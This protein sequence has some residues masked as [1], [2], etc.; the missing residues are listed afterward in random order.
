MAVRTVYRSR[1]SCRAAA[2]AKSRL[3]L[4]RRERGGGRSWSFRGWARRYRSRRHR[5]DV[6]RGAGRQDCAG[7]GAIRARDRRLRSAISAGMGGRCWSPAQLRWATAGVCAPPAGV[8]IVRDLVVFTQAALGW[9]DSARGTGVARGDRR[10]SVAQ[11]PRSRSRC[12]WSPC[13]S[14]RRAE[15][16]ATS[17][18]RESWC[19]ARLPAHGSRARLGRARGRAGGRD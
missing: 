12:D 3:N 15:C 16:R 4:I 14:R 19:S 10:G 5:E 1:D 2:A 9:T 6:G 8:E 17:P 7:S 18:R 13:P 11:A